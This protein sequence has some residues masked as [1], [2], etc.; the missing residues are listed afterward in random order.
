MATWAHDCVLC[1][2]LTLPM[3]TAVMMAVMVYVHVCKEYHARPLCGSRTACCG[4]NITR[5]P[6]LV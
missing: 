1:Q 5:G 3:L 4:S 6:P 2:F